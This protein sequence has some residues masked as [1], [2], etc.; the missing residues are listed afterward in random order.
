MALAVV[1]AA[2]PLLTAAQSDE[3]WRRPNLPEAPSPA[4]PLGTTPRGQDIY[5]P[6]LWG[7]R[8]AFRFGLT[9]TGLTAL[10]GITVGAAAGYAGGLTQTVLMRV[11]DAFLAFPA[12]AS[13]WL[14]GVVLSPGAGQELAPWQA[15][16]FRFGISPV[17]VALITFSWM[18]YARLINTNVQRIKRQDFIEA[19]HA[20]GQS[21][22][23]I[24]V[25][26]L[27]PNAIGPVVVL[28]ARDVGGMV[29]LAVAFTFIGLGFGGTQWGNL[30]VASRSYIIGLGGN[31]LHYWWTFVPVTLALIV[32][33]AGWNLLGDGLNRMLDPRAS[34]VTPK[35]AWRSK[36]T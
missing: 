29:V 14:F 6:L 25:R 28:A 27:L 11:T 1:A 30:L 5:R 3:R 8:D 22:P 31:P 2:A 34:P 12:I 33:G 7:T 15:G 26:H 19:A 17:M 16:L 35:R 18:P 13:V 4:H 23:R 24:I 32:F 21:H 10:F 36:T 20:L 9:V